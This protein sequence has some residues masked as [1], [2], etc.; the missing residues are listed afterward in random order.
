VT[1]FTTAVIPTI[2]LTA[3]WDTNECNIHAR[4]LSIYIDLLIPSH[5]LLQAKH[6][7]EN[8]TTLDKLRN[9]VEIRRT[10]IWPAGWKRRC[11]GWKGG[12]YYIQ[13]EVNIGTERQALIALHSVSL[14]RCSSFSLSL[15]HTH[16]HTHT[17][18][19]I[20]VLS[21]PADPPTAFPLRNREI[22]KR[23]KK[24]MEKW[25]RQGTFKEI[26]VSLRTF[27]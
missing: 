25:I 23:T 21:K 20:S 6:Q 5:L 26:K 11:F 10:K 14:R 12:V 15:S 2:Y 1:I 19:K 7:I 3:P 4:V 18:R 22:T 16:T 9:V 8:F 27:T 13:G 24:F 17:P